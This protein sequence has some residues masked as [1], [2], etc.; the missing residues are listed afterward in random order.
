MDH[1]VDLLVL[2]MIMALRNNGLEILPGGSS[3][4]IQASV[5]LSPADSPYRNG[6]T[7]S[8]NW[9]PVLTKKPY[10]LVTIAI[11]AK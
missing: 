11:T 7:R 2:D 8:G 6:S 9:V 5:P 3:E 10:R 1:R 4:F